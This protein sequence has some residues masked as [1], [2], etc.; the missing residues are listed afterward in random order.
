V[1]CRCS[2]ERKYTLRRW[3][4]ARFFDQRRKNIR[5]PLNVRVVYSWVDATGSRRQGQ[6]QTVNISERGALI[7]SPL[8]PPE[9]AT[10]ELRF[11]LRPVSTDHP[12]AIEFLMKATVIRVES[13]NVGS[14]GGGFAVKAQVA[15]MSWPS[16]PESFPNH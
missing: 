16:N 10:V 6:G 12:K 4:Q 7:A 11:F 5:F 2:S 14:S 1:I 13:E 9:G 8:L 15:E 3:N